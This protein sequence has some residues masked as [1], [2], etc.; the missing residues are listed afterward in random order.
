MIRTVLET[1]KY[2]F[3]PRESWVLR[4]I[5]EL[6]CASTF[7]VMNRSDELDEPHYLLTRLLLRRP[8]RIL[9]SSN[10]V[11]AYSAELGEE[12]VKRGMRALSRNFDVPADLTEDDHHELPLAGPSDERNT[13][14]SPG[15]TRTPSS[16]RKRKCPWSDLPTGL[17]PAEEKADPQLAEA[18]RESLWASKVGRVELDNDGSVVHSPPPERPS[19]SRSGSDS[20]ASSFSSIS[21]ARVRYDEEFSL[22]PRHPHPI[23]ALARDESNLGL[24]ELMS[25]IPAD[26]L[27]KV[28]RARKIPLS[29]LATREAVVTALKGVAKKQTVLGFTP[30]KGGARQTSLPFRASKITS[31]SLLVAQL[32]PY[33]GDAA[34]QLTPELHA[35]IARVNLIFSRTPPLTSTSSSLMLP[36]ILVTSHKRRYPDYG[37]PTRSRI[38]ETRDQLLEWER[39][40]GWEALVADALGDT[41]A[42]QRKIPLPGF[43]VRKEMLGR[44]KGAKVVKRVWEGVWPIWL[45]LVDGDGGREVDARAQQGGLVGDRF[46]TG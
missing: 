6:P 21:P 35:L 37:P 43:G 31:I 25:S 22:S 28:A 36:S 8:G 1:E 24:A 30:V 40:V 27:R 33:L 2:L 5:L 44:A 16:P 9:P 39:A 41:W 4:R 34:I 20:S 23:T 29:M 14:P 32:L 45:G 10:L 42:E 17:T 13:P 3:T 46:K 7:R 15:A 18:I 19:A 11:I 38:W 26:D 12:G